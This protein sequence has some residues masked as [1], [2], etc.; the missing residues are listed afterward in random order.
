MFDYKKKLLVRTCRV[1]EYVCIQIQVSFIVQELIY[2]IN[3]S[4][5]G[6]KIKY[7]ST[8]FIY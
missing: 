1:K 3:T 5:V 4:V 8:F 7:I 6:L 2:N